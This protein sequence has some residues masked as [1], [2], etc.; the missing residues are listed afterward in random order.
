M[1]MEEFKRKKCKNINRP[2]GAFPC[3]SNQN[4][5]FGYRLISS[6]LPPDI[7]FF[8]IFKAFPNII[9]ES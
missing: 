8:I 4:F 9:P 6:S 2:W 3:L 1:R 7:V 5:S